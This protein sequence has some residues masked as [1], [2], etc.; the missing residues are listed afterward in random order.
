MSKNKQYRIKK[1]RIYRTEYVAFRCTPEEK[2]LL[3][4]KSNIFTEGNMSEYILYAALN[5]NVK[6][7]DLEVDT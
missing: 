5:Y 4:L 1:N 2:K 6:Y 7:N 3:K